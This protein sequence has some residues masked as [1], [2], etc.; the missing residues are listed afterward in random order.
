MSFHTKY[1][2][3]LLPFALAACTT[4]PQ[5]PNV[6]VLPGK[7]KTLEQFQSDDVFC[8]QYASMLSGTNANDVAIDNGVKSAALGTA[9]G[10]ASGALIGGGDGA[11]VGAGVGLMVG[12]LAGTSSGSATGYE[13]Q[14]RYDNAYQQCM[15]ARG[16]SIPVTASYSTQSGTTKKT[17]GTRKQNYYGPPPNTKT[18]P[19]PQYIVPS[20]K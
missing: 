11:A 3:L 9:L 15:F 8:R 14:I 16:H 2:A 17:E 19:P 5:G 1:V 4:I 18:P 20:N 6:M 7:G 13:A 10:A 12:G